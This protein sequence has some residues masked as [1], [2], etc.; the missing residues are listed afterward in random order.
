V[1]QRS[2]HGGFP[3]AQGSSSAKSGHD[4]NS[5]IRC[6]TVQTIVRAC[7]GN[8]RKELVLPLHHLGSRQPNHISAT[9]GGKFPDTYVAKVLRSGVENTWLMVPRS[10]HLSEFKETEQLDDT[11]LTLRITGLVNYINHVRR[12][13]VMS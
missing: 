12:N 6:G 9:Y 11:Q 7:H 3:A 1:S 10:A 5:S 4:F 2:W 8:D 13:S